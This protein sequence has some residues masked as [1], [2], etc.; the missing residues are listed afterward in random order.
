MLLLFFL[1]MVSEPPALTLAEFIGVLLFPVGVV[2]GMVVAW[3]RE[4]IGGAITAGSLALFYVLDLLVTGTFPGGPFFI[5]FAAPGLLFLLV[6]WLA[7]PSASRPA[8]D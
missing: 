7:R 5:L 2:A 3:W 6:W 4:V 1:G 8:M